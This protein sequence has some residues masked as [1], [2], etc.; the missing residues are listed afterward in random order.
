MK[1]IFLMLCVFG[2]SL[3]FAE[4][5]VWKITKGENTLYIGGS[6][7]TLRTQDYPL[8]KE[9]DAAFEKS[10]ILV[11][12]ADIGKMNDP[13]F[14]QQM[15][16]FMMLPEGK[17]LETALDKK[18][19]EQF[20][21]KCEELGMPVE[22]IKNFTPF[23]AINM[24]T[25]FQIQ[26]MGFT[27]QGVD[28]YYFTKAKQDGK[29]T[30]FLESVEFQMQLF[31]DLGMKLGDEYILQ[32]LDEMDKAEELMPSMIT[33]WRSGDSKFVE[34]EMKKMKEKFPNLYKAMI[35]DRNEKW[36]D[37]IE[38]YLATKDVEFIVVGLGHMYGDE[39]LL[40]SLKDRGYKVEYLK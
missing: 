9:F 37:V 36:L 30:E 14:A 26:K 31:Y 7:H 22:L 19:Y 40:K 27:P 20:S 18:T 35:A 21:A 3:A 38:K 25:I 28:V 8:P 5:S 23:S 13:T 32:A 12:E 6:V 1:K 16:R 2:M 17:T 24:L 34:N 11:F 4:S 29:R 33:E 10:D 15:I 39:G